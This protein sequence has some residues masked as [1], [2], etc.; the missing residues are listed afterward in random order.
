MKSKPLSNRLELKHRE[1][2][3]SGKFPR[4]VRLRAEYHEYVD[5]P[6]AFLSGLRESE[7]NADIFSFLQPVSDR[8]PRYAYPQ[9]WDAVA[10]LTIDSYQKWWKEQIN[11]KTRNMIRKAGK[12]GVAIEL[13][14]FNDELAKGIHTIYN[15]S[16]LVQGRLSKH[17]G[18]DFETLKQAHATFL[19]RSVFVA[20]RFQGE[21]IGFIKLILHGESA[22]IM[23]IMSLV[24]QRDKSPSNALLAKAVELCAERGI[25]WLQ[26]GIWSRRSLGEFKKHHAFERIELPRYF[27][28]LNL[29]GQIALGFGLHRDVRELIPGNCLDWLANLRG[30]WYSFKYRSRPKSQGL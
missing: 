13:A 1:L 21:L 15:E 2:V 28:P 26:Y 27:A 17:Y 3:I 6:V 24:S 7:I 23:Q 25:R 19:E 14:E 11:D 8:I 30:R 18:K 22:S 12:K 9:R 16:P 5:D 10:V 29:R 20:A 4:V